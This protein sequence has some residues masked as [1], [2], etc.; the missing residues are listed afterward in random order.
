MP[1][2]NCQGVRA[3]ITPGLDDLFELE[4]YER[5]IANQTILMHRESVENLAASSY[6]KS[7]TL[8]NTGIYTSL[9][10]PQVVQL[11]FSFVNDPPVAVASAGALLTS[12]N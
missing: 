2:E 3:S 4:G 8:N 9:D 7:I 6:Y 12:P 11:N 5:F 10:T 1:L